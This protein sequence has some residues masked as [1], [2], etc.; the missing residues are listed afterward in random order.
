MTRIWGW[1]WES[2]WNGNCAT[3][4][5]RRMLVL[6]ELSL[7]RNE[8]SFGTSELLVSRLEL[9][10]RTRSESLGLKYCM[11]KHITASF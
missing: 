1:I 2:D 5:R 9:D 4:Q 11:N 7:E 8:T 10:V 3:A 6:P